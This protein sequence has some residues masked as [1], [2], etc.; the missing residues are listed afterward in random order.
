M[1]LLDTD[2][3]IEITK[4]HPYAVAQFRNLRREDVAINVIVLG[5]LME[6]SFGATNPERVWRD[7]E[8]LR[9]RTSLSAF[10]ENVSLEYARLRYYLR[11]QGMII[12]S[13][14]LWI[15][16]HA[17]AMSLTLVTNNEREF[18]RVPNLRIE[19]WTTPE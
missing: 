7:I 4:R 19:N 3:C 17:I 18:S 11:R 6:G 10:S 16:A 13:N 8:Q 5:E 12:G 9:L 2:I 14:D 1:Y 15:A